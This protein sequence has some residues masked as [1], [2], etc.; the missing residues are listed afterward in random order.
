MKLNLK[1]IQEL[2][3]EYAGNPISLNTLQTMVDQV[4]FPMDDPMGLTNK[5]T[6]DLALQTLTELGVISGVDKPEVKPL[7]S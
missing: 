5:S 2:E 7:H 3:G 4:A 1:R 6:Y